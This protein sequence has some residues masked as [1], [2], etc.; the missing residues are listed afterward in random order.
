MHLY[1]WKAVRILSL[2]ISLKSLPKHKSLKLKHMLCKKIGMIHTFSSKVLRLSCQ[3]KKRASS[4]NNPQNACS[5]VKAE[6]ALSTR[7]KKEMNSK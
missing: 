2:P 6:S 5:T 1:E 3:S 4:G 7:T